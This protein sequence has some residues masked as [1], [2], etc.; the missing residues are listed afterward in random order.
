MVA[1]IQ[2]THLDGALAGVKPQTPPAVIPD[3]VAPW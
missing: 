2:G 1:D 3:D